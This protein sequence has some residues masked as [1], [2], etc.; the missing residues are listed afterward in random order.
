MGKPALHAMVSIG[1]QLGMEQGRRAVMSSP[2][3]KAAGEQIDVAENA[4]EKGE[5]SKSRQAL[6]KFIHALQDP[7][8]QA[9]LASMV[10]EDGT[11][12]WP[13]GDLPV[14][15]DELEEPLKKLLEDAY[16]MERRDPDSDIPWTGPKSPMFLNDMPYDIRLTAENLRKE[17]VE[18]GK[19]PLDILVNITLELGMEQGR[20]MSVHQ[21]FSQ[22]LQTAHT[23]LTAL[24][25]GYTDQAK[26]I[27]PMLKEMWTA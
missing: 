14:V 26:F 25:S 24:N 13:E 23:A 22:P 2:N 18:Q 27:V 15:L 17:A 1:V 10:R 7:S 11:I 12:D 6:V 21:D 8:M 5:V 4:L 20:R 3:V 19:D 9:P 16:R